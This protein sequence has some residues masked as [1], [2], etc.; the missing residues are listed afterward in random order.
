MGCTACASNSCECRGR[1]RQHLGCCGALRLLRLPPPEQHMLAL[2]LP[3][4]ALMPL[5]HLLHLPPTGGGCICI[6][7]CGPW[8]TC[9]SSC[10]SS[11]WSGS[12]LPESSSSCRSCTSCTCR[13]PAKVAIWVRG[14]G[15]QHECPS[16]CQRAAQ[17]LHGKR[18]RSLASGWHVRGLRY[19]LV[20]IPPGQPEVVVCPSVCCT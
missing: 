4:L 3:A 17:P 7:V 11:A 15:P 2:A 14:L 10:L 9:S 20:C 6:K 8:Y 5:L 1:G 18:N 12:A 13:P 16:S 19:S